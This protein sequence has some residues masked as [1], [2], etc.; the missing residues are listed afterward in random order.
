MI[1]SPLHVQTGFLPFAKAGR[2][3]VE[4]GVGG[5]FR[6]PR[7]FRNISMK[8][9]ERSPDIKDWAGWTISLDP[10]HQKI[11]SWLIRQIRAQWKPCPLIQMGWFCPRYVQ[12][13][14]AVQFVGVHALA[15]AVGRKPESVLAMLGKWHEE[16]GQGYHLELTPDAMLIHI[17]SQ[18][19]NA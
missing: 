12:G 15:D 16:D 5:C 4:D 1:P 6:L 2:E 9:Q 14:A 8:S 17:A 19:G 3:G 13:R 7:L 10:D 18:S 11:C